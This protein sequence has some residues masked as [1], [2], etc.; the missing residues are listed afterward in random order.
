MFSETEMKIFYIGCGLSQ[1]SKLHNEKKCYHRLTHRTTK[2]DVSVQKRYEDSHLQ[3]CILNTAFH[4]INAL[5]ED[6][7][8]VHLS[9]HVLSS[10]L[11]NW[12]L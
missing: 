6:C 4:E 1:K 9:V 5:W 3:Q 10:K 11:I 7:I 2:V 8:Y 12:F